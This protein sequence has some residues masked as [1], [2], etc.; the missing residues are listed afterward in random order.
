[1]KIQALKTRL[2][3]PPND[4]L[5]DAI[6]KSIKKIP[7]KSILCIT[8]KVVSI[9]QGRCIPNNAFTDKDA[10]I[11]K[12]SEKYVERKYALNKWVMHTIKNN[13]FIPSAGIDES[14]ARGYY[15]LWPKDIK[16]TAKK[17]CLWLRKQYK[18]KN[19]GVIITDSHSVPLRRGVVGISLGHY[20]FSAL[21][22]Y[23]GKEDLF[24]RRLKLT[25]TNI[26]DSMA[27]AAVLLM[28]EG[29]EQTPLALVTDLDFIEFSNKKQKITKKYSSLEVPISEDLYK[30][31]FKNI[32]WRKGGNKAK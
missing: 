1:M 16:T 5:I 25:Q 13:L 14:N 11:I 3:N 2:L 6:K 10:L 29:A 9:W 22:D 23:R 28:G 12:E 21:K 18:L 17:L 26:V 32:P 31:F 24:G 27:A 19:C 20:G 4:D 30:L 7:E 15:I 8:S